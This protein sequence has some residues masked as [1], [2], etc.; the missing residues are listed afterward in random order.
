MHADREM[1]PLDCNVV[2]ATPV[3]NSL[4]PENVFRDCA[5]RVVSKN[6]VADLILLDVYD[7]DAILG[8]DWLANHRATVDYFRKEITFRKSR[9]S[10]I[11]LCGERRILPSSVISA[12]SVRRLH[13]KCCFA[14][15][16]YVIDNQVND[17][18]L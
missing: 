2:V 9:E 7:F 6:M 11:I 18:K 17:V 13:R 16:A 12:I 1:R 3:G 4:L 8:M 5:V 10:D 14:F 15:L